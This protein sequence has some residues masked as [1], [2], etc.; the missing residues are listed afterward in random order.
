MV[1]P[2][3]LEV[4]GL[5]FRWRSLLQSAAANSGPIPGCIAPS[6][7]RF[8]EVQCPIVHDARIPVRSRAEAIKKMSPIT[9]GWPLNSNRNVI[10]R[11][12][13]SVVNTVVFNSDV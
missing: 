9:P 1:N 6:A 11:L 3:S 8:F 12:R 4:A 2:V 5:T 10:I 7:L 13:E